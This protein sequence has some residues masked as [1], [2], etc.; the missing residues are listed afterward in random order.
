MDKEALLNPTPPW[1]YLIG[2][3]A[4]S[5]TDFAWSLTGGEPRVAVRI[6]RGKKMLTAEALFNEFAAAMQF[7]YYFGENWDAFDECL[8]DLEW[9]TADAYVLVVT[10]SQLLLSRGSDG[11]LS[12]LID[13]LQK[14]AA[15]W[16]R[17]V[18]VQEEW[19]RPPRA[20]HVIFQ[21][22]SADLQEVRLRLKSAGADF[23]EAK[24]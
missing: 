24:L 8:T 12:T 3:D 2:A 16:A 9:M 18:D 23:R 20:F 17:P 5:I 14:A 11:Q 21:S 7:P 1:L 19:G 15:E 13:V 22:L 6:L 10:D 4:S